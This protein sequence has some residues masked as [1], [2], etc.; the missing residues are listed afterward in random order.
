MKR[1]FLL[2]ILLSLTLAFTAS[3][4]LLTPEKLW[5]LKRISEPSLSPNGKTLLFVISTPCL[6]E[7]K[8]R[9]DLYTIPIDGGEP[10]RLTY[11]GENNHNGVWAPDGN[12]IAFISDRSG[13]S[14]VYVMNL[15]GGD[16]K[17]MTEMENETQYL[18]WS[19]DGKWLAFVSDVKMEQ[20]IEER[21]DD[22]DKAKAYLYEDL[23]VRH[24]DEWKDEKYRHIFV[25][26][27]NGGEPTDL[28]K[29]EKYD[30]PLKPFGGTSQIAW[31]PSGTEIAYVC[32]KDKDY[33]SSTNSEIYTVSPFGGKPINVTKGNVSYALQG[34]DLN[35][36]YSPNGK[37]IAFLSEKT[38]GYEADK[39]RLVTYS[40]RTGRIK[41]VTK[42][43]DNWVDEFVWNPKSSKIYFS[44]IV[45]G[46]SK[47]Y[48]IDPYSGDYD[49]ILEGD[50]NYGDRYLEISPDGEKLIFSRRNFN[51]PMEI[52]S[53]PIDGDEEDIKQITRLNDEAIKNID[54]VK[55]EEKW[56]T[57]ADNKKMHAWVIYPPNFNKND[58][59]PLITYCQ[60]GPQQ[61]VSQYWS[62]GWSFALMASKGYIVVAPN[63][64]G[65]P[66]FGQ[67]W[68]DSISQDWGGKAMQDLLVAT[69]SMANASY[70]D[71]NNMAAIGGSAGG[72]A[73]FWLEGNHDGR[74]NAFVS[75]CGVFN[76]ESK[77]GSTEELWFPNWDYGGEFLSGNARKQYDKF[78]PHNFSE[79]WE[80]PIF[81]I[82]GVNDFRVPYDQSLQ[83][84][85]LAQIKKIPSK[86]LV[87]P[88][89]NHWIL[90]PQEK[91]FWYREF[92]DF[93][94]R[95]CK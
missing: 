29:D 31:S 33:E 39:V 35:P 21:Y 82:T 1:Y 65:C 94:D 59:Y 53:M 45:E 23:P 32:K 84:F 46:K 4:E 80:T 5:S 8:F 6:K 37:T 41:D 77:H 90:H 52:V 73:T 14:Q 38:P 13:T 12:K 86:L 47:I 27:T 2:A 49:L 3:A 61:A 88:E 63:R 71:E 58:E 83:A 69:D 25:V 87:Y 15:N 76:M 93:L 56:F 92:F 81:I 89:E 57:T 75:H 78:S 91:L 11:Q 43:F 66:G 85:T 42:N 36:K 26:S 51:H 62:Y 70:V 30:V 95:Y 54:K 18:S 7:N 16:P 55:F 40:K 79:N 10:R 20:T 19:P 60:G 22:L 50:F 28:M 9:R 72:Y 74:F 44:S 64:R 34:F 68:I 17:Q 48:E 67:E 24:W